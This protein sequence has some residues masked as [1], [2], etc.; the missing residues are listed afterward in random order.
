MTCWPLVALST[1]MPSRA[2]VG[3]SPL[4]ISCTIGRTSSIGIAKPRP[5]EPGSPWLVVV[6][7]AVWIA[8]SM[9]TTSPA[10]LTSGP[11]ELPGLIAASVWIAG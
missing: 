6:S 8:E 10:R 5:I 9:P 1:L 2:W 4:I 3:V 11:P 7:V